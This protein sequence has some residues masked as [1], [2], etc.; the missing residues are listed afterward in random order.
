MNAAFFMQLLMEVQKFEAS[1]VAGSNPN[2]EDFRNWLN[3]EKYISESPTKLFQE[4]NKEL[5]FLENEICK[6]VLLVSRYA[7]MHIRKGLQNFPE[8]A[9]EEFTYLFRIKDEPGLN[10]MALIEKNAHEKPTGMHI[11]RRLLNYGLIR[12]ESKDTDKRS[13]LLFITPKGE[14]FFDASVSEVNSISKLLAA[15]LNVSEKQVLLK[16]LKKVNTFHALMYQKINGR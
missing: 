14:K 2:I 16:I 13:K 1:D 5:D 12:E 11:I 6:Q 15:D 7:R 3:E 8:L 4:N 10:K 9:N